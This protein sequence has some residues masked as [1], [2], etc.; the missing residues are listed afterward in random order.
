MTTATKMMMMMS[1]ARLSGTGH[2]QAFTC[3]V[4]AQ[5]RQCPSH[6]YRSRPILNHVCRYTF[7]LLTR[8]LVTVQAQLCIFSNAVVNYHGSH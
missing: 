1:D 2:V 4:V 3:M 5:S 8:L 6:E 7:D